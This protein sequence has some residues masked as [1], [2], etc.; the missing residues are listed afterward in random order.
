MPKK[1]EFQ[2]VYSITSAIVQDLLRIERL[3][4]ELGN[5]EITPVL[6]ESLRKSAR[7]VSTHYSTA[8]EGNLLSQAQV[9]QVVERN[10]NI[11]GRER[12]VRE[13]KGYYAAL[14]EVQKLAQSR[15]AVTERIIQSIHAL[16]MGDGRKRKPTP[17]RDGQNVIRD[18]RTNEIVYLPPEASVVPKLM[19]ELVSWLNAKDDL[20]VP[21]RAAIAHYQFA[22]IHPYYDGNGRTARLLTTLILHRG[23]YGMNGIYSLEEY[24][25][26]DLSAYYAALSV[27]PSH[28]YH[29]GRAEADITG[30]VAYFV[31]GMAAAFEKVHIH[32]KKSAANES[33]GKMPATRLDVKKR[34]VL[35]RFIDAEFTSMDV[36]ELL[37]LNRRYASILCEKWVDEGFLAVENSSKKARSYRIAEQ[38]VRQ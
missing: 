27:G 13:V 2:P 35:S 38:Y 18:S 3:K 12:D 10:Q 34:T 30:W 19:A 14:E 37:Q 23:G 7:L 16:V 24:Y 32:A 28:N 25:A 26:N 36:A 17:Y 5:L 9:E 29:L 8:I 31:A 1:Q 15:V 21:L 4:T 33:A 11:R 6:L 20:P 22:T